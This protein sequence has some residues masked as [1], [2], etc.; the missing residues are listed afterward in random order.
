MKAARKGLSGRA[1]IAVIP[2]ASSM[3]TDL[4][5]AFAQ[6]HPAVTLSITSCTSYEVL[7][8]LENFEIDTGITYLENEPTGRV[9]TVPLYAERYQLITSAGQP[10]ADQDA[11]TW[12]EVADAVAVPAH[13]QHA[14]PADHRPASGRSRRDRQADA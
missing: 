14:E 2:T 10:M 1:R 13:P 12:A 11:V 3:V 6:K 7:S 5:T 8:K 4:T 9:A